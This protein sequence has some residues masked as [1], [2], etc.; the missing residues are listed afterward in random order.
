MVIGLLAIVLTRG[1]EGLAV[2]LIAAA[3][4]QIGVTRLYDPAYKTLAYPG[5]DVP[6]DRGVCTD[7]IIRAVRATGSDLQ[8]LVHEDMRRNFRAYPSKW[9]LKRPDRN[10]DH[11]RVP[12]LR[13]YFARHGKAA[14]GPFR[15][16]DFVTWK[17]DTGQDHIGILTDTRAGKGLLAVHNIGAGTVEEDIL[18]RFKITGH[19]RWK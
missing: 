8:R 12:N 6:M 17:L 2:K 16:G 15:P 3:R 14:S 19:Y 7:V 9:G 18:F 13:V 4:S 11:R 10:I 1:Q 5:G